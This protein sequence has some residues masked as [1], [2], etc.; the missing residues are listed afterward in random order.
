MSFLCSTQSDTWFYEFW[1][2]VHLLDL[3]KLTKSISVLACVGREFS[4][5]AVLPVSGTRCISLL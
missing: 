3:N 2:Q 1:V 5:A 4:V